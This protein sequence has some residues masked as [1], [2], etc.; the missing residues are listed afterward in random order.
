MVKFIF[1]E[2]ERDKSPFGIKRKLD[3]NEAEN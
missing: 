2:F 1:L 3:I